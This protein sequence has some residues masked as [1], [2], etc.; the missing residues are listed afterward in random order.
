[1]ADTPTSAQPALLCYD[2]SDPAR[3]AIAAAGA[4][5]APRPVLVATAWQPLSI[6]VASY[7]WGAP[8]PDASDIDREAESAAQKTAQEGC[9][10]AA[11]AGFDPRPVALEADGPLWQAIVAAAADHDAAIVVA[12]SRGLGG[13]KSA[14]LGSV[15][16]GVLHHAGRPVLVIPPA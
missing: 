9:E 10:H 7:A 3:H 14:L 4:L 5:L 1:M 16:S 6:A 12:G 11:A 15:S 2:G 8:I 13:V